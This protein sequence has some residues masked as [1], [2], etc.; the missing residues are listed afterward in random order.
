MD[1]CVY[2]GSSAGVIAAVSAI[3]QGKTVALLH[4]GK[5]L[6]G[7]TSGGLS[8]TDFWNKESIGGRARNFYKEVGVYY[9]VS[10]AWKFEPHVAEDV[11]TLMLKQAEIPVFFLPVSRRG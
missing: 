7:M 5:H 11:F 1:I 10:E 6:G 4:P 2:G 8:F 9:G 3:K